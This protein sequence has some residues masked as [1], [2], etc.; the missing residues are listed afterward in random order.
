MGYIITPAHIPGTLSHT[1]SGNS[2]LWGPVRLCL[3]MVPSPSAKRKSSRRLPSYLRNQVGAAPVGELLWLREEAVQAAI[4]RDRLHQEPSQ[5]SRPSART[6]QA[7]TKGR[8]EEGK[9][10][11]RPTLFIG[12]GAGNDEP[13]QST[14]LHGH[15][16]SSSRKRLREEPDEQTQTGRAKKRSW[17]K[18]GK[19]SQRPDR[20]A[21]DRDDEAGPEQPAGS[22]GPSSSSSRNDRWRNRI[23]PSLHSPGLTSAGLRREAGEWRVSGFRA[24][25]E[26]REMELVTLNLNSQ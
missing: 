14:K 5:P 6:G 15:S 8:R 9:R 23:P 24:L 16:S 2:T 10:S 17:G 13:E 7:K 26:L 18:E 25:I 11:P 21:G 3:A 22:H 19:R 12:A 20:A 4:E 1:S